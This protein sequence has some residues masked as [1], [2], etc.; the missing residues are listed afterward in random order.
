MTRPPLVDDA[1]CRLAHAQDAPSRALVEYVERL[2]DDKRS[3][4]ENTRIYTEHV[5]G[6]FAVLALLANLDV[7]PETTRDELVKMLVA[8]LRG[9][10]FGKRLDGTRAEYVTK[11]RE[12]QTSTA[13]M[14]QER[15]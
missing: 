2:E 8:H 14:E 10:R 9:L 5:R 1:L 12:T 6:D 4:I 13:G 15:N 7:K 11:P 3:I